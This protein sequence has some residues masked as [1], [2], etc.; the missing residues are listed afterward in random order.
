MTTPTLIA[1]DL[2]GVFVP[3]IWIAVAEKTQIAE[4]RLTTRDIPNYDTLMKNRLKILDAHGLSLADI[5]A[6][7]S[8]LDPLPGAVDFLNWA[9][10]AC[11]LIVLT[12]SFYEFIAP[13]KAK[14]GNPTIFCNSLEVDEQQRIAGYRL[15]QRDGK[16]HAVMAF[17]S[18]GFRVIAGGDSYNDTSML[19]EADHGV[20]FRPPANVIA[21]FPQYPVFA[22]YI[23]LQAHVAGLLGL[24]KP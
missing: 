24:H 3:E 6:V 21:E 20:L 8:T 10:A 4:L 1:M 15:R 7:I 13:L 5:Q 2:E 18:I 11:Q 14:L 16:K 12:D 19:A 17:K 23:S 9:R 22:D